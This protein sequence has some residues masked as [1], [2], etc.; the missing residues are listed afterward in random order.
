M[1]SGV[2]DTEERDEGVRWWC[3]SPTAGIPAFRAFSSKHV[4]CS[5]MELLL[6]QTHRPERCETLSFG[7]EAE[8][9]KD[10]GDGSP[11]E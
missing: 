3:P 1:G 4:R 2:E 11:I 6:M 5:C 7:N 10:L 8:L 9:L